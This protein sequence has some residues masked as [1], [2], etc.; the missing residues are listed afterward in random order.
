MTN[1]ATAFTRVLVTD[2]KGEYNSEF[3]VNAGSYYE[4]AWTAMLM[5]ESVDNFISDSRRDFTDAA[6]L[7]VDGEENG[8]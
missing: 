1:E 3:T 7:H 2:D 6:V 8:D 5:T 4:K